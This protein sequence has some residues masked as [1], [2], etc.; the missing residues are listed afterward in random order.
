ME[1]LRLSQASE[2]LLHIRINDVGNKPPA[3]VDSLYSCDT[4]Q[5][6][7]AFVSSLNDTENWLYEEGEDER[8]QVY[9][10]KLASL[11]AIGDPVF[12][13]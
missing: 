12:R 5:D 3:Q 8:K 9:V 4:L 10:D 7:A 1:V 13:R 2:Q 6:R 11:R